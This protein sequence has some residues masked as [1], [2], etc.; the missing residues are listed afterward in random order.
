[1]YRIINMHMYRQM[2]TPT[3]RHIQTQTDPHTLSNVFFDQLF[4]HESLNIF[5]LEEEGVKEGK[6]VTTSHVYVYMYLSNKLTI[7]FTYTCA[8]N[9]FARI[10]LA[11]FQN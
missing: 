6:K 4:L 8:S 9:Y 10:F 1:M 11:A 7:S 3:N 2:Y 5:S